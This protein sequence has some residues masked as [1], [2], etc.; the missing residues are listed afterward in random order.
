MNDEGEV[1]ALKLH[2][3]GRTSFRAVKSKRD[4]LQH[5]TSFRSVLQLPP[6]TSQLDPCINKL[7]V[8]ARAADAMHCAMTGTISHQHDRSNLLHLQR[9]LTHT[10]TCIS[11]SCT[12]EPVLS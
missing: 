3:L 9:L 1:L 12:L 2:R 5:R 8:Q 4:Y 6:H 10:C 11:A 7:C